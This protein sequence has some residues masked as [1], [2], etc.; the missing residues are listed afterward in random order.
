MGKVNDSL[1]WWRATVR[2]SLEQATHAR[3]LCGRIA[4]LLGGCESLTQMLPQ[5]QTDNPEYHIQAKSFLELHSGVRDSG[6]MSQ[7]LDLKGRVEVY[8]RLQEIEERL[9]PLLERS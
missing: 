7:L 3:S 1:G 6:P 9:R 8:A 4:A 2:T 5:L